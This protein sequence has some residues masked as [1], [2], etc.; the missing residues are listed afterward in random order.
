MNIGILHEYVHLTDI[1]KQDG[2]LVPGV[3]LQ[4]W[5]LILYRAD[6]RGEDCLAEGGRGKVCRGQAVVGR[7]QGAT[8]VS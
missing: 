1:I 2:L 5:F 6:L 7:R 4:P 3:A 8:F